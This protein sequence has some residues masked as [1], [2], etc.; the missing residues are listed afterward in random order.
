[1]VTVRGIR[2]K[3]KDH[4]GPL[5]TYHTSAQPLLT[6]EISF[7]HSHSGDCLQEGLFNGR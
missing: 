2:R 5:F 3:W 4:V 6:H 1:M 7:T